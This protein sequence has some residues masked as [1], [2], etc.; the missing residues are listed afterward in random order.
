MPKPPPTRGCPAALP[1]N[2]ED[3]CIGALAE[4]M[5][6]SK[7]ET[8]AEGGRRVALVEG[9][10]AKGAGA[11]VAAGSRG[12]ATP[13]PTV[14]DALLPLVRPPFAAVVAT[15]RFLVVVMV[16]QPGTRQRVKVRESL[17]SLPLGRQVVAFVQP[18]PPPTLQQERG[19]PSKIGWCF[20]CRSYLSVSVLVTVQCSK[21]NEHGESPGGLVSLSSRSCLWS[22]EDA[23]DVLLLCV[24]RCAWALAH[25]A[26]P[27]PPPTLLGLDNEQRLLT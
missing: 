21:A 5:G 16:A 27:A 9:R 18:P 19:G 14:R 12:P 7:L 24:L 25:L 2:D 11:A 23:V 20:L 17:E 4:V 6:G 1:G 8:G 22:E 10:A 15:G 13:A 3:A 26:R